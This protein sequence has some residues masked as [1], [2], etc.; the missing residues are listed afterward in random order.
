[1]KP[2][3]I[4][5]N[6]ILLWI[7]ILIL[8]TS[9]GQSLLSINSQETNPPSLMPID[10]AGSTY[11]WEDNFNDQIKI[12]DSLSY[13]LSIDTTQGIVTMANTY[14]AWTAYPDWLRIKPIIITNDETSILYQYIIDL[15]IFY[16][17]DMQNDFDDIRLSLIHI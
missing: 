1:M 7:S 13:N 8:C 6:V 10:N 16:D 3:P 9:A 2:R 11:H 5:T 17:N 4:H 15:T 14:P 12:D